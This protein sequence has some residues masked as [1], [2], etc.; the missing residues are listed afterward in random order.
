[1]NKRDELAIVHHNMMAYVN[2]CNTSS[3]FLAS[4]SISFSVSGM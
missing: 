4:L 1:M 2:S 3:M